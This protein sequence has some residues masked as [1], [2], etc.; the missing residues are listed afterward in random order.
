MKLLLAA[1]AVTFAVAVTASV[2]AI[3]PAVGTAPWEDDPEPVVIEDEIDLVRC[4]AALSLRESATL[5]LA[6]TETS[7]TRNPIQ[8]QISTAEAEIDRYC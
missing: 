8:S 3:W 2:F 5:A 7:R 4:E 6:S 1:P